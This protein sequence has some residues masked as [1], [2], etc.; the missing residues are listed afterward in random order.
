[1]RK[2][3]LV[4]VGIGAAAVAACLAPGAQA[5]VIISSGG[6]SLRIDTRSSPARSSTISTNFTALPGAQVQITIPSSGGSRLIVARFTGTAN[7]DGAAPGP[8]TCL[9]RIV[10][11][12]SGTSTVTELNP[13]T[14][15]QPFSFDGVSP[16]G[17]VHAIERSARL[18]PGTYVVRVQWAV[19][20]MGLQ[21]FLAGWHFAV[22]QFE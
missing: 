2:S 5:Q 7:C 22:E 14:G 12:R 19:S 21:F 3:I 1:M 17:G 15:R 18:N 4:L 13:Q 16:N 9:V 6:A 8:D 11:L 20:G 10:A